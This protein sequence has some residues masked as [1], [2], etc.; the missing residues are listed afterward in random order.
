M[1]SFNPLIATASYISI[2]LNEGS[3]TCEQLIRTYLSQIEAHNHAGLHLNALISVAPVDYLV[4]RAR[5]LDREKRKGKTRGALH[6]IP[7]VV[8]VGVFVRWNIGDQC[9]V[10]WDRP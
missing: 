10:K 8:K 6:G 3:L 5:E 4:E 2:L 1:A 9:G 7:I